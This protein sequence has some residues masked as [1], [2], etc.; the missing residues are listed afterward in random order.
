MVASVRSRIS[1]ERRLEAK[2]GNSSLVLSRIMRFT[3]LVSSPMLSRSSGSVRDATQSSMLAWKIGPVC[4]AQSRS[5]TAS[6]RSRGSLAAGGICSW[7]SR[8]ISP[9]TCPMASATNCSRVGK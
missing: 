7:S 9:A 4:T 3:S 8:I 2:S 6:T 5:S 1:R